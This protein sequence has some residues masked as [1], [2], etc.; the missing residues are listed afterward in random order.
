MLSSWTLVK[1]LACGFFDRLNTRS[2]TAVQDDKIIIIRFT[3]SVAKNRIFIADDA[4]VKLRVMADEEQQEPP[5]KLQTFFDSAS[6]LKNVTS[7]P[8]VYRMLDDNGN[9]KFSH[10]AKHS[11]QHGHLIDSYHCSRYNTQTKRLT[12]EMFEAV[13]RQAKK[14]L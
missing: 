13:F 5:A 9:Y 12:L 6:F 3:F 2:F 1:D 8:G 7:Q 14:L 11:L 10:N 4:S